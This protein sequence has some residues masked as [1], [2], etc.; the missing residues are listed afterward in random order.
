MVISFSITNPTS[1]II[2]IKNTNHERIKILLVFQTWVSTM[3]VSINS[4]KKLSLYTPE[5][6]DKYRSHCLNQLPPHM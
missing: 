3:L 2:V 6:I 5:V 4:Y 1:S